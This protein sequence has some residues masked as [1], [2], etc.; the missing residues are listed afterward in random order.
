MFQHMWN[1]EEQEFI[2]QKHVGNE[3]RL[4]KLA[5]NIL[6]LTYESGHD[7]TILGTLLLMGV[8]MENLGLLEES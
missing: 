6:S 8:G 4:Y 7:I 2:D 3:V 1:L 5:E